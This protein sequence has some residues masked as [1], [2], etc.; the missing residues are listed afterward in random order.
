MTNLP[1]DSKFHRLIAQRIAGIPDPANRAKV[2]AY[3]FETGIRVKAQSVLSYLDPIAAMGKEL[4]SRSWLQADRNDI[5]R[6][7]TQHA[8]QRGDKLRGKDKDCR[9]LAPSTQVQWCMHL[10]AFYRWLLDGEEPRQFRK[11]PF[12]K[13]DGMQARIRELALTPDEIRKLLAGAETTRDRAIILVLIEAGFRVSE[14]AALR[15]DTIHLEEVGYWLTLPKDE[16]FLKTDP[17]EV[18]VPVIAAQP[19]LQAWL[20]D[21]PRKNDLRAPLFVNLSNRSHGKRMTGTTISEAIKRCARRAGLRHIH[22]HMLRHTSATLKV[23]K[24]MDPELIRLIHGW[25]KR[26]NMLAHYTHSKPHFK[27][28][29]LKHHGRE[30]HEPELLDILGSRACELCGRGNTI[31]AVN[32]ERCGIM[33]GEARAEAERRRKNAIVRL[34]AIERAMVSLRPRLITTVAR[35]LGWT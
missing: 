21:H 12:R 6:L 35:V 23:A 28:M 29:V 25:T 18:E 22:G 7:I 13:K 19:A 34:D 20:D 4:D 33:L 24:G 11:L 10:K 31:S 1:T 17:R 8:S 16:P 26:S 15:L 32:C 2:Q 5:I 27:H 3:A 14:A 9:M 30:S